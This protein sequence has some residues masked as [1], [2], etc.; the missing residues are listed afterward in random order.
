MV[1]ASAVNQGIKS[2]AAS[3]GLPSSMFSSKSLRSGLASEQRAR[4]ASDACR[5]QIG[6]WAE[7][8]RVPEKHYVHQAGVQGVLSRGNDSEGVWSVA[9]VQN[10]IERR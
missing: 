10:L 5:N 6:G 3:F 1:T 9:Q 4:G 8:S 7:H 2:L